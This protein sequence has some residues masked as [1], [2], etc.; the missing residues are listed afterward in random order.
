MRGLEPPT[1]RATTWRSNQLSYNHHKK[2]MDT[3]CMPDWTR[4]SN[5]Q[6][7]RLMLYPLSYGHNTSVNE[8]TRSG[9][10]DS[11]SGPPAPKAGTLP[12]APCPVSLMEGSQYKT[13]N[14]I[15]KK[16]IPHIKKPAV[17]SGAATGSMKTG[18]PLSAEK[19]RF[20]TG[21]F[22]KNPK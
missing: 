12:A 9:H 5:P 21:L 2:P 10:R 14:N 1:S 4:T 8:P 17:F 15:T 6:L 11:N 16:I 22:R 13:W 18:S 7:R 19:R 3:P 20:S